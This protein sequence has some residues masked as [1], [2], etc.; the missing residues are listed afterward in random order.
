M[1]LRTNLN[2]ALIAAV[3]LIWSSLA[4]AQSAYLADVDDLPLAPGL[5]ED[6]R[7]IN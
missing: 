2:L 5:V 1:L 6:P 4:G 7:L 3:L